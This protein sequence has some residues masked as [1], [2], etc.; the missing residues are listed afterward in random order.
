MSFDHPAVKPEPRTLTV[1]PSC[2][3]VPRIVLSGEWVRQWGFEIGDALLAIYAGPGAIL[4][5]IQDTEDGRSF[6]ASNLP[7]TPHPVSKAEAITLRMHPTQVRTPDGR[8][9][10]ITII[11]AWLHDWKIHLGD[12]VSVTRTDNGDM[13]IQVLPATPKVREIKMKKRLQTEVADALAMLD[14]HKAAHP[15]LYPDLPENLKIAYLRKN[16]IDSLK[17][18]KPDVLPILFKCA[19]LTSA[20]IFI[21]ASEE[22]YQAFLKTWAADSLDSKT[23]YKIALRTNSGQLTTIVPMTGDAKDA[24]RDDL[25]F[26]L[27]ISVLGIADNIILA[28]NQPDGPPQPHEDDIT[29]ARL[30]KERVGPLGVPLW[31]FLI[32]TSDGYY[33]FADKGQL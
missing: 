15:E 5:K 6:P 11:G 16:L 22:A 13:R 20:Q 7:G 23:E 12:R 32:I 31:D 29:L 25:M 21:H 3:A 27:G 9:P 24:I 26:I 1:C 30:L 4:L 17:N 8:L 10:K 33:S 18:T 19:V 28:R 14:S 2:R